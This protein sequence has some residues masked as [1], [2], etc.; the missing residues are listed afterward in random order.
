MG[1]KVLK[2]KFD[3]IPDGG[4]IMNLLLERG[5][6]SKENAA[7]V[8][9]AVLGPLADVLDLF[10]LVDGMKATS[11]RHTEL[12]KE[13]AELEKSV[14]DLAAVKAQLA[15]A[16]GE[17]DEITPKLATA[18]AELEKVH[19]AMNALRSDGGAGVLDAILGR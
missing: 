8:L 3:S 15:A 1:I 9:E 12:L 16:K 5:P 11:T 17:M 18:K 2:R 10:H 4:E 14:A 13:Q 7:A 19:I 6:E